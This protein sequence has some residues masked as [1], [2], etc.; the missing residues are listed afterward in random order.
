MAQEDN[1]SPWRLVEENNWKNIVDLPFIISF[2]MDDITLEFDTCTLGMYCFTCEGL[3][4]CN[5]F[6]VSVQAHSY[7]VG[8]PYLSY[9]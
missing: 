2:L 5:R 4:V 6:L 1:W 3:L 7:I 8:L 9:I